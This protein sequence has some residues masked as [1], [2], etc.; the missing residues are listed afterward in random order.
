MI[1]PCEALETTR[2]YFFSTP[3]RSGLGG[4][5][6]AATRAAISSSLSATSMPAGVDV[7]RDRVAVAHDR[8]RAAVRRLRCD[9]PDHQPVRRTREAAVGDQCDVLAEPLADDRGGHMQ[10]LAHARAPG[11]PLVANHDHGTGLDLCGP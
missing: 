9:M 3:V 11:R 5:V 1:A 8:K 2:A 4:G 7:E 6:Y 10:H